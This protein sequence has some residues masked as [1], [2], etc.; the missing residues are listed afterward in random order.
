M[1]TPSFAKYLTAQMSSN[2]P[3]GSAVPSPWYATSK[4]AKWHRSLII[5]QRTFHCGFVM[6]AP[7]GLLQHP[8]RTKIDREGALFAISMTLPKSTLWVLLS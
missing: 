6:S 5:L 1:S 8:W 3:S 7:L 4:K 2:P